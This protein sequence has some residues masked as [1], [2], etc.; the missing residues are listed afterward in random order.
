MLAAPSALEAKVLAREAAEAA[1]RGELDDD[2]ADADDE[3]PPVP[4]NGPSPLPDSDSEEEWQDPATDGHAEDADALKAALATYL[5]KWGGDPRAD[6]VR[7]SL[8][9]AFEA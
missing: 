8:L 3:A 1:A 5:S 4:C 2:G 7:A 6:D 9:A